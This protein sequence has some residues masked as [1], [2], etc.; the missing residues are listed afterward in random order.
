MADYA[1]ILDLCLDLIGAEIHIFAVFPERNSFILSVAF[2]YYRRDHLA[3][4][5]GKGRYCYD[6]SGN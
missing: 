5:I 1:C 2:N 3:G 6:F 4:R